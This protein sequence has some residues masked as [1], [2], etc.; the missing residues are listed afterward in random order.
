VPTFLKYH[1]IPAGNVDVEEIFTELNTLLVEKF[2]T[3][4]LCIGLMN[5]Q[6]Y[7]DRDSIQL[8]K[9]NMDTIAHVVIDFLKN[10][11]GVQTAF[12]L[13]K[14][15][16]V[17]LPG[18]IKKMVADGFYAPRS[19]DIQML[20]EPQWIEGLLR[21]GTTHGLFNPYDTHIPL[22]WYGWKIKPGKTYRTIAVTDIAPTVSALLKIQM[23]NGTIGKTI[24]EVVQ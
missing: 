19:G 5:Y 11:P 9:L 23:P 2:K 4:N 20:F 16:K 12:Q 1:T 8:K 3:E 14:L 13:D 15:E 7:L 10:Q 17:V 6:V 18:T 24:T 21:G 22:I